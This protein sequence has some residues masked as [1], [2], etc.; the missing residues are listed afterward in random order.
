MLHTPK[1]TKKSFEKLYA[2]STPEERTEAVILMLARSQRTKAGPLQMRC[3]K[4]KRRTVSTET[5]KKNAARQY[6][7][8]FPQ[9]R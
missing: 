8:S 4:R 5:K 6:V 7:P 3:T 2:Q 9:K 1:K